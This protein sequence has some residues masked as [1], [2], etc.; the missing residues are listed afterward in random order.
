MKNSTFDIVLGFYIIHLLDDPQ[1]VLQRIKQLLK[2][3]GLFISTTPCLGQ[4]GFLKFMLGAASLFGFV[5]KT[6]SFKTTGLEM[7]IKD[8]GFEIVEIACLS[9]EGFQQ[10]VAARKIR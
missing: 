5:P 10:Y 3:G 9:R 4:S 6:K 2:P 1:I 7:L 8:A